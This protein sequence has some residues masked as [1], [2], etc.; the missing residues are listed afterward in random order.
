M[1][2][3]AKIACRIDRRI[4][5]FAQAEERRFVHTYSLSKPRRVNT[6]AV[7]GISSV[8]IGQFLNPWLQNYG[9]ASL[10]SM[11][12]FG[13]LFALFNYVIWDWRYV[14]NLV[15]IPNLSGKWKGTLTRTDEAGEVTNR[16]VFMEITQNFTHISIVFRGER[17]MSRSTSAVLGIDNPNDIQLHWTYFSEDRDGNPNHNLYGH[18]TTMLSLN[19][20]QLEGTYYSTKLKK[21][22]LTVEK[23]T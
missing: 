14:R 19:E 4:G 16:D 1:G 6:I 21:G 13:G 22:R 12:I 17:S 8:L 20:R 23:G 2:H 9:I 7:I 3:L 18:G 10:G 15:A 5:R 11:V